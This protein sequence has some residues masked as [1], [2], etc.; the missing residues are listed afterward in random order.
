MAKCD[1]SSVSENA[2]DIDGSEFVVK[3]KFSASMLR[4]ISYLAFCV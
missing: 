4:K 2:C 3:V 1:A